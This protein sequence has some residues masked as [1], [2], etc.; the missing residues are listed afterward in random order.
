L[1]ALVVPRARRHAIAVGLGLALIA[2]FRVA[3]LLQG[4][5][6]PILAGGTGP[7]LLVAFTL[8]GGTACM[9]VLAPL[10]DRYGLRTALA[11]VVVADLATRLRLV[12]HAAL[13]MQA[14]L[15]GVI[16]LTAWALR[17]RVRDAA[18]ATVRLPSAGVIPLAYGLVTLV[19][20]WFGVD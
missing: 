17:R 6:E 7:A 5:T 13:L 20:A 18:G 11:L 15:L 19:L 14:A 1:V 9:L 2:G 3:R 8:V 16:V 4:T 12:G 10:V